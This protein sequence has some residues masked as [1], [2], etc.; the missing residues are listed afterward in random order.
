MD[1]WVIPG[2]P[3]EGGRGWR[4]WYSQ[5]GSDPF[6][7]KP[8][9]VFR[10]GQPQIVL[11]QPWEALPL[12]P[13]LG[14]QVGVAT[15]T[16]QAP[17]PGAMYQVVVP[18]IGP[19]PFSWRT[20]PVSIDGTLEGAKVPGVSFLFASCFW[21]NA[22]REGSYSS[23]VQDLT[24]LAD[25]SFKLLIGDQVYQDWPWAAEIEAPAEKRYA[26]RYKE[27]WG[28]E[29]YRALLQSSP[30]FLLADDHEFWNDYPERQLQFAHTWTADER[31]TYG[32][33]AKSLYHYFQGSASPGLPWQQFEIGKAKKDH[34]VHFFIADT[35][36]ERTPIATD[37][38]QVPHFFS[39]QQWAALQDWVGSLDG[40]GILVLGQPLYSHPGWWK[41]HTLPDF[42]K[43]HATLCT[44][45]AQSL[46][47]GD[48]K[49]PHDILMLSGDIHIGRYTVGRIAGITPFNEVHELVASAASRI[50]PDMRTPTPQAPP[51]KV[52][53]PSGPETIRFDVEMMM[54]SGM[55]T[56]TNNIGVVSM[57]PGTAAPDTGQP[58][59]RFGL[60]IWQVRPYDTRHLLGRLFHRPKP[61]GQLTRIFAKELQLR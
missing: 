28:D 37:P 61:M 24:R 20:L 8:V 33:V 42:T 50:A 48:G 32:K 15:V 18:E 5:P 21:F 27:Y 45:L 56:L 36:S 41:D 54:A 53:V 51:S 10:R 4:I 11:E 60:E 55:P 40:P 47:A 9:Q 59:V 13:S 17:V 57:S 35:R 58:R 34:H 25:P 39:E 43:D 6:T 52:A 23:G 1:T 30:N 26:D 7:P 31:E 3:L 12:M 49:L 38:P 44:L 46:R 14:R 22:D 19:Q 29:T 2:S 16:L